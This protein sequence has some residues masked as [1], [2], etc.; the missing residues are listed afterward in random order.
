VTKI[1]I[2]IFKDML[3]C[4]SIKKILKLMNISVILS[5]VF[6]YLLFS[7]Q[8][9]AIRRCFF[10]RYSS[11]SQCALESGRDI[12]TLL[13]RK[14]KLIIQMDDFLNINQYSMWPKVLPHVKNPYIINQNHIFSIIV[15]S[16]LDRF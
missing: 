13:P 2:N 3:F 7:N 12:F 5:C 8:R 16:F 6:V 10:S 11:T 15:K 9:L 14:C 1:I 4:C